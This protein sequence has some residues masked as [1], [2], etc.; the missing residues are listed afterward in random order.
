MRYSKRKRVLFVANTLWYLQNF[1]RE[2]IAECIEL[3]VDVHVL[4]ARTAQLDDTWPHGCTV[5]ELPPGLG[6]SVADMLKLVLSC[7]RVVLL[8]R[9]T[10]VFSF[11]PIGSAIGLLFRCLAFSRLVPNVSGFGYGFDGPRG[12]VYR[13]F[14]RIVVVLSEVVFLQKQAD[15][16]VLGALVPSRRSRMRLLPGSGV[17]P[18]RFSSSAERPDDD[19]VRFLF[20][21]RLLR[22]KGLGVALEAFRLL[23]PQK[24]RSVEF[25][26]WGFSD[27]LHPDR[28]ELDDLAASEAVGVPVR[29]RGYATDVS[30]LYA[31]YDVLVLPTLYNEGV[32]RVLLEAGAAGL[33]VVASDNPGCLAVIEDDTCGL[34]TR[35]GDADSMRGAFSHAI[36]IGRSG[37]SRYG[38]ALRERVAQEF[39]L[40][41][42]VRPYLELV[43]ALQD[44]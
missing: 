31:H 41:R 4:G 11:T 6:Y 30:D 16:E 25:D 20:I 33:C 36:S 37:R 39:R 26:V 32:P 38:R 13:M 7:L 21:G 24:K 17:D 27:P 35:A 40:D 22:T 43:D 29:L 18:E 3:G 34:I 5:H 8:L 44:T 12:R 14:L 42:A 9:P 15:L 10:V 23:S 2:T 1:R 19:L 28:F